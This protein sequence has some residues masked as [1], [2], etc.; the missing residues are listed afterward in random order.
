MYKLKAFL[1]VSLCVTGVV[2]HAQYAE[3]MRALRPGY[4]VNPWT[5]GERVFQVHVGF[6]GNWGA[7]TLTDAVLKHDSRI[8]SLNICYGLTERFELNAYTELRND[9]LDLNHSLNTIS[10]ISLAAFGVRYN[11]VDG[12][13]NG[14]SAGLQA[15]AKLPI[16][17]PDYQHKQ[18]L[19][20]ILFIMGWNPSSGITLT[21]NLGVEYDGIKDNPTT[22]YSI[23]A[24]FQMSNHI[25]AFIETHN[26]L[27]YSYPHKGVG[28]YAHIGKNVLIDAST[29]TGFKRF[30]KDYYLNIG[31]SCRF[32]ASR[33]Q[34][35][36]WVYGEYR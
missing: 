5:V 9:K 32:A 13:L 8:G 4:G 34:R 33:T 22:L 18:V 30:Q 23:K 25:G 12:G 19:P 15:L 20:K 35:N 11:I 24:M 16:Q 2:A 17:S 10:G 14:I 36:R 28:L 21:G 3:R 27:Q 1:I 31:L 7:K 26:T 6:D 29:G